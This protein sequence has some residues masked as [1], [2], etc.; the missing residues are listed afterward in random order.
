MNLERQYEMLSHVLKQ[1]YDQASTGKGAERHG[2][3]LPFSQQ[4]ACTFMREH[5]ITPAMFQVSKKANELLRFKGKRA[6]ERQIRE[7]LGIIVYAAAAVIVLGELCEAAY[8]KPPR[9]NM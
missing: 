3:E 5:G 8:E 2:T 4:F 9:S 6:K 7:L 1:A